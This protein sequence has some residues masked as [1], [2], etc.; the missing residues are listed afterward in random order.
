MPFEFRWF[1]IIFLTIG[2]YFVGN[3][4]GRVGTLN[5]EISEVSKR[6]AWRRREVSKGM[7]EDMQAYD[8]DDK[9]D[10]YEFVVSSLLTLGKIR[11]DDIRPIMDKFR[12][13]AGQRGFIQLDDDGEAFQTDVSAGDEDSDERSSDSASSEAYDHDDAIDC[14]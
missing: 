9:V 1:Q 3:V 6:Y 4:L 5:K 12:E 7:I 13:A 2:T 14:Y 8:H 11:S 10:Q